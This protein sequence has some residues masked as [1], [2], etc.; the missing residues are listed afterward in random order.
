[1]KV[2]IFMYK[3]LQ[4]GVDYLTLK[5]KGVQSCTGLNSTLNFTS[6]LSFD[7]E[8]VITSQELN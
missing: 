4:E 3:L 1:M 6:L 2:I 7:W 5:I 8:L